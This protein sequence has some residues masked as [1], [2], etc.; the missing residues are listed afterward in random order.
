MSNIVFGSLQCKQGPE[1]WS[2]LVPMTKYSHGNVCIIFY[3]DIHYYVQKFEVNSIFV[4]IFKK[5][6]LL[7]S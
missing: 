5:L 6:I 7:L 3:S 4:F 2:H 1:M